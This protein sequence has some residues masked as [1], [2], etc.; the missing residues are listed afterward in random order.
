MADIRDVIAQMEPTLRRAFLE[1]VADIRSEAQ[2][3]LIARAIEEG[4]V[5]DA[6]TALHLDAAFFAPLDDA[7]LA[8][9]LAGGRDALSGLPAIAD[10]FRQAAWS[11]A[12]RDA[13]RQ[14]NE[15]PESSQ[16]G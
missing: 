3:A 9:Y 12:L 1:S 14:L 6:L 13:I 10:P 16:D 2:L 7:W 5:A 8:A 11:F 4:R 15:K